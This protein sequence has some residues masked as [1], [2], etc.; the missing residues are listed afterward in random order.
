M[1]L[2]Q[3]VDGLLPAQGVDEFC[4]RVISDDEQPEKQAEYGQPFFAECLIHAR[5][6]LSGNKEA[7]SEDEAEEPRNL[8][9]GQKFSLPVAIVIQ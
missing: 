5:F 7:P 3:V 1:S 4:Y 6:L 2:F 9:W 8:G